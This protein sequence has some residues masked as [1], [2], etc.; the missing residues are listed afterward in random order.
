[1]GKDPLKRSLFVG[2]VFLILS[3]IFFPVVAREGK[4]DFF[5]AEISPYCHDI[6]IATH[7]ACWVVE[8]GNATAYGSITIHASITWMFLGRFP[9]VQIR[10]FNYSEE[11]DHGFPT[12]V[13]IPFQ[14]APISRIPKFG[15]YRFDCTVN[16]HHTIEESNYTNND[17]TVT[18][19]ITSRE[20]MLTGWHLRN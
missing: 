15:C 7:M 17:C 4:P 6:P 8:I 18:Y 11:Y 12:G 5:I 9:V 10:S 20:S 13:R 3:T 19:F 2:I 1:M 16:P 14:F